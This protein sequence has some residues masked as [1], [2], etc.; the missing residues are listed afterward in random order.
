MADEDACRPRH[1]A[2]VPKTEIAD[3][4]VDA[5]TTKH[6]SATEKIAESSTVM[7]PDV[8]MRLIREPTEI[9]DQRVIAALLDPETRKHPSAPNPVDP[10]TTKLP[11]APNP[12]SGPFEAF[13]PFD[14]LARAA[15][16]VRTAAEN[17]DVDRKAKAAQL[18]AGCAAGLTNGPVHGSIEHTGARLMQRLLFADFDAS[19][20]P[21]TEDHLG[22][23]LI[24][25]ATEIIAGVDPHRR[26]ARALATECETKAKQY[27]KLAAHCMAQDPP[28]RVRAAQWEE[29]ADEREV[30]A[31]ELRKGAR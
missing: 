9:L 20:G 16:L 22:Q 26:A 8:P 25:I 4:A 13:E 6:R 14:R 10:A 24:T 23:A 31:R 3:A 12:V 17:L 29:R 15:E 2:A 30:I 7:P 28:E 11:S 5:E 21:F 18:L 27:R 1:G 19:S